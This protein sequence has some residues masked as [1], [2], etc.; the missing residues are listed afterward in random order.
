MENNEVMDE[1]D[2]L[3]R[4]SANSRRLLESIEEVEKSKASAMLGVLNKY[5]TKQSEMPEGIMGYNK[6]WRNA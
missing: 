2:Y 5:Q 6:N 3:L 4:S 1:T